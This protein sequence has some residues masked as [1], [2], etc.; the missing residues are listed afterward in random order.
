M[1]R[2]VARPVACEQHHQ[3]DRRIPFKTA[4]SVRNRLDQAK[5]QTQWWGATYILTQAIGAF[6]PNVS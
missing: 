5:S 4:R 2:R 1:A 6:H 3:S